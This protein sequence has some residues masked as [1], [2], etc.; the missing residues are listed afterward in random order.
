MGLP[1]QAFHCLLGN[2]YAFEAGKEVEAAP[3]K[4]A[5]DPNDC[6]ERFEVL[7]QWQLR[8]DADHAQVET[9]K[10]KDEDAQALLGHFHQFLSKKASE[11]NPSKLNAKHPM[12]YHQSTFSSHVSLLKLIILLMAEILHHLG[13][14]WN[15]INNGI[16]YQPQLVIAGLKRH[17]QY[18]LINATDGVREAW[19]LECAEGFDALDGEQIKHIWNHHLV[20]SC[21]LLNIWMKNFKLRGT[22]LSK[23]RVWMCNVLFLRSVTAVFWWSL[24]GWKRP[25]C[26]EAFASRC[27]SLV[28]CGFGVILDI[29]FSKLFSLQQGFFQICV[30]LV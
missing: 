23:G 24:F 8:M 27:L 28:K 10:A 19:W 3:P 18:H 22:L 9:K 1:V 25:V 4:P 20:S 12:P 26:F 11:K 5:G 2:F 6:R 30:R 13:W 15:P 21:W 29:L 14:C 17:Q 7:W 16:N